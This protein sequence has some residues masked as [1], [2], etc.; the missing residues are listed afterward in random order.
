MKEHVQVEYHGRLLLITP[1]SEAEQCVL[2]LIK[3]KSDLFF[4][5]LNMKSFT[6]GGILTYK[7]DALL[8]E[9]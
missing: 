5:N 4:I 1:D 7:N 6:K 8:R 2:I 3:Y 9:S